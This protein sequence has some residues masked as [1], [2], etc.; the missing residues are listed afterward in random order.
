VKDVSL[1]KEHHLLKGRLTAEEKHRQRINI[2]MY[3]LRHLF[4]VIQ[5]RDS[6]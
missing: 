1:R 5:N 4:S 3:A 2:E 6:N